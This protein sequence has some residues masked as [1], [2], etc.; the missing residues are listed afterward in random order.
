MARPYRLQAEHCLYQITS[1]GDRKKIFVNERDYR[2]FLEYFRTAK[3][4]FQ[5]YL[6]AYYLMGNHYHL[7]IETTL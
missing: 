3:K 7:L 4:M 6:C 5:F 2:K 1:R